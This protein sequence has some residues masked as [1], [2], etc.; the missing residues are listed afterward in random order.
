M[1]G[2]TG[3]IYSSHK[4]NLLHSLAVSATALMKNKAYRSS[5]IRF[6]TKIIQ[7]RR[8]INLN[9]KYLSNNP[10]GAQASASQPPDDPH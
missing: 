2:A 3:T 6:A 7:M 1:L 8:Y 5:T 10:N 4:R 9:P